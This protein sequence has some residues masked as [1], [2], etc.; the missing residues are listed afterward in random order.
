MK[1]E[2]LRNKH[3]LKAIYK[4]PW[5]EVYYA[6]V[7]ES[8]SFEEAERDIWGML[9]TVDNYDSLTIK[10]VAYPEDIPDIETLTE[11]SAKYE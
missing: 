5:A 2:Q 7:S 11:V 1:L 9:E 10:V 4:Y 8:T 3:G 6:L